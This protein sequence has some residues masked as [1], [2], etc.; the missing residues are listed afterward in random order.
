MIKVLIAEDTPVQGKKLK[1]YLEK[2]GYE[3]IWS[4][5]GKAALK[6]LQN[7]PDIQ[8]VISDVQMPEMD[9]LELLTR[10]REISAYK[11]LPFIVLTTLEDLEV[12]LEALKIGASDF[13]NKPFAAEE[14]EIRARNQIALYS[15]QKLVEDQN[16]DLN[17]QLIEKN[18]R[19]ESSFQE[20]KK[21]HDTLKQMQTEVVR[22]GKMTTLGMLGAGVA[23]EINNPLAIISGHNS[24]LTKLLNSGNADLEATTKL[25]NSIDLNIK[26]ISNIVKQ[27][28]RLSKKSDDQVSLVPTDINKFLCELEDLFKPII[29]KANVEFEKELQADLPLADINETT[30]SQ[31]VLNLVQNASDAMENCPVKKLKVFSRSDADNVYLDFVD[32]GSGIPEEVQ[33]KIFDAF[34]TTKDPQKGTGLGLSL[35]YTFMKE[36]GGD[37]SF[38]SSHGGTVFTLRL[39]KSKTAKM[40]A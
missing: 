33:D 8:L 37:I 25:T 10:V 34:F 21:A 14:L 19:L 28:R 1:F 32:S 7:N 12:K 24:R 23:H 38:I 3:V 27:L 22:M 40:V 29:H 16:L 15:Y 20:L 4:Y 13:L 18:K 5:D 11:N 6:E 30:Y 26:R 39:P 2:F 17:K 9:G 35:C 31:C 36:M